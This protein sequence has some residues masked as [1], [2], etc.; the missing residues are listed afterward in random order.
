MWDYLS[1]WLNG[2]WSL[3]SS[4]NIPGLGI[5]VSGC[6][7]GAAAAAISIHLIGNI[8]GF[9]VG[10]DGLEHSVISARMKIRGG[11]NKNIHGVSDKRKGD[12]K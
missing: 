5:S 1:A 2:T 11:N 3:M 10:V 8:F 7:L 6:L 4:T 12:T 9:S